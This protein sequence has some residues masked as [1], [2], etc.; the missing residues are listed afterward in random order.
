MLLCTHARLHWR[1]LTALNSTHC[2]RRFVEDGFDLDLTFITDQLI[3]MGFPSEGVEGKYRNAMKDVQVRAALSAQS[4]QPQP[5]PHTQ[6]F[7]LAMSTLAV[8]FTVA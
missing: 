3:A 7:L 4:L 5:Q 8:S 6:P 1:S 2:C